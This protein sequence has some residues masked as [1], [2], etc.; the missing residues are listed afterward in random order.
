MRRRK[1]C[2]E[3]SQTPTLQAKDSEWTQTFLENRSFCVYYS[4]LE[5]NLLTWMIPSSFAA[6]A[7]YIEGAWLK[8]FWKHMRFHSLVRSSG[9]FQLLL[10]G[11]AS[12]TIRADICKSSSRWPCNCAWVWADVVAHTL[13]SHSSYRKHGQLI[14]TG[15]EAINSNVNSVSEWCRTLIRMPDYTS[16]R[17]SIPRPPD[18]FSRLFCLPTQDSLS[19]PAWAR[20]SEIVCEIEQIRGPFSLGRCTSSQDILMSTYSTEALL[21]IFCTPTREDWLDGS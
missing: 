9:S 18:L 5:G 2:E 17:L 20:L 13:C 1:C 11:H 12:T 21:W 8:A 6:G 7:D 19:L 15:T 4:N 3:H 16:R 10:V 14:S